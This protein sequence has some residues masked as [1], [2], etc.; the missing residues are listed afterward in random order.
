MGESRELSLRSL[1]K[2]TQSSTVHRLYAASRLPFRNQWHSLPIDLV[3]V[4][5]VCG[6]KGVQDNKRR[7]RPVKIKI[8]YRNID[9]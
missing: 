2:D 5:R 9:Y 4:K 7:K 1:P 6:L 8:F 3:L